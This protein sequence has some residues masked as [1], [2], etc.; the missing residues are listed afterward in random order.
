MPDDTARQKF[1]K[2]GVS[3]GEIEAPDSHDDSCSYVEGNDQPRQ[4]TLPTYD[5]SI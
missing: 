1:A 3:P 5:A 2:V 4:A